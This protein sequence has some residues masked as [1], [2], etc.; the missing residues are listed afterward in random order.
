ML[1]C[2][3]HV[4][5]LRFIISICCILFLYSSAYAEEAIQA[6]VTAPLSL[7]SDVVL[8]ETI[9]QSTDSEEADEVPSAALAL[10]PPLEPPPLKKVSL[11]LDWYLSP[12]HASLI[13]AKER[14]LFTAQGL[15]MELQTPADPSVA[16]KLLTAGE[17][18]LALTRQPL[19]HLFAHEGVPVTRIATLI[20]TPLTAVIVKGEAQPENTRHLAGLHYGYST[21][22]GV[23]LLVPELVPRSVR[24][25]DGF[26]V[27]QSVHFNA[28]SAMSEGS[29]DAVADGF[30]HFLPHQLSALGITTHTV[31]YSDLGV[32]RH[33]G[34]V[35]VANSNSLAK[36]TDTWTRFLNAVEEA[37]D[38]IVENPAATWQL[39]IDTNPI[40]DNPTNAAAWPDILRRMALRPAALDSRRYASFETYLLQEG[41]IDEV[42]PVSRLA[43]DP[44]AL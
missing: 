34:L 36:H 17:V 42:L 19:L 18:D 16:I 8:P 11:M 30:Y 6:P 3:S 44:F 5:Q 41:L 27:P 4:G 23:N 40:L 29:I 12:Q 21:R 14:G 7:E 31:R 2:L 1:R 20:E 26:L 35:I 22:E 28:A 37:N 15:E 38:W 24:Q 32:P 13:V 25:T 39:I 33:D 9:R 43:V 10:P